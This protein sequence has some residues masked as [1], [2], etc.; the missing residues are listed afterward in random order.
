MRFLIALIVLAA[1]LALA[2][3][4]SAYSATASWFG[5]GLY[6]NSMACGGTLTPYT[7]GVA[8]KSLR[9]GTRLT[10][11]YRHRC[12]ATRVVDRGPYV[13]SRQFD[14]AAGL[15]RSLGFSG[16]KTIRVYH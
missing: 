15:A 8:H 10:V 11:C 1:S 13:G 9:C 14:L 3:T 4:A 7:N 12:R 5:P 16:V 6:G 2:S